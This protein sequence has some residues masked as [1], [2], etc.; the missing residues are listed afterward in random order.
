MP[1]R[2]KTTSDSKTH[3]KSSLT[4]RLGSDPIPGKISTISIA[5]QNLTPFMLRGGDISTP[6][7]QCWEAHIQKFHKTIPI[8]ALQQQRIAESAEPDYMPFAINGQ[9]MYGAIEITDLSPAQKVFIVRIT[10]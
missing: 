9:Q 4:L 3:L 1:F 5:D 8:I 10:R 7:Q 2:H 6:N